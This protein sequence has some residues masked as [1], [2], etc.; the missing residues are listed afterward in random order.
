MSQLAKYLVG[1]YITVLQ[2][3]F[4]ISGVHSIKLYVLATVGVWRMVGHC[5]FLIS[6]SLSHYHEIIIYLMLQGLYTKF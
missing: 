2:F 4:T 3:V 5:S 1:L 6:F